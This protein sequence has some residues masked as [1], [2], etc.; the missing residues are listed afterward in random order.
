MLQRYFESMMGS[1]GMILG[2]T[3]TGSKILKDPP[4]K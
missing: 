1:L 4:P 2:L 3:H